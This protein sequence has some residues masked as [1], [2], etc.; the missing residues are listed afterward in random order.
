MQNMQ[1]H[2]ETLKNHKAMK[3]NTEIFFSINDALVNAAK[4]E[5][6]ENA[7]ELN[8]AEDVIS[9]ELE[10][11]TLEYN[12]DAYTDQDSSNLYHASY[13]AECEVNYS[14]NNPEF[15]QAIKNLDPEE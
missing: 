5:I 14:G 12:R 9:A 1:I 13:Y 15:E 10:K 4:N 11:V 6:A 2:T 8:I 3:L 7:R